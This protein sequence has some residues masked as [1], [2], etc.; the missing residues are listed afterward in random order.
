M[1]D[2]FRDMMTA[3]PNTQKLG[4]YDPHTRKYVLSSNDISTLKCKLNISRNFLNV[5]CGTFPVSYNLFTIISDIA[6]TVALVNT[7]SGTSWLT[8][9]PTSGYGTL[10]INGAVAVNSTSANR[11]L[12]IVVTYCSTLTKTFTLTQARGS[13]ANIIFIVNNNKQ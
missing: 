12:R 10:D 6:W 8:G 4:G 2:Y 9:V 5:P 3:S 11:S 13:K 7:G 1:T